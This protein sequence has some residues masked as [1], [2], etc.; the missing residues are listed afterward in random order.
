VF[1]IIRAS[2]REP[3]EHR[4]AHPVSLR[5]TATW[6][7]ALRSTVVLIRDEHVPSR[8]LMTRTVID[9]SAG[10]SCRINHLQNSRARIPGEMEH[11]LVLGPTR[12]TQPRVG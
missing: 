1:L 10:R 7:L 8:S 2:R 11:T 5:R 3:D 9:R 4:D 6:E 12:G